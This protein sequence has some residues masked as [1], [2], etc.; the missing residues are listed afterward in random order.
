[1]KRVCFIIIYILTGV[2]SLL[3]W[4]EGW[5]GRGHARD[6]R[7]E[8]S[9]KHAKLN[10]WNE[11][12]QTRGKVPQSFSLALEGRCVLLANRHEATPNREREKKTGGFS[13]FVLDARSE[14]RNG[15]TRACLTG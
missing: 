9:T 5:R 12:K 11:I 14:K 7:G 6:V 1:M 15:E 10:V 13:K 4:I 3:L 8:R 2:Q